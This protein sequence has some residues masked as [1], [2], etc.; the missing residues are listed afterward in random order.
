METVLVF[1]IFTWTLDMPDN[2]SSSFADSQAL[3][4]VAKWDLKASTLRSPQSSKRIFFEDNLIV[5]IPA[6]FSHPTKYQKPSS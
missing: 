6:F 1:Q 5:P 4:P 3:L 2:E